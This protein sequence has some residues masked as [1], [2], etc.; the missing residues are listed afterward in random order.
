MM[1]N[2]SN[3]HRAHPLS[4]PL[5]TNVGAGNHTMDLTAWSG[6][7]TDVNDPFQITVIEFPF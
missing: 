2:L 7:I 6:T 3:V 4:M 1:P 5:I